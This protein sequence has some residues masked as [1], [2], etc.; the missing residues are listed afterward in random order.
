ML[1]TISWPFSSLGPSCIREAAGVHQQEAEGLA[2]F[3]VQFARDGAALGFLRIDEARGELLQLGAAVDEFGVAEAGLALEAKD[4]DC[5]DDG[6][7]EAGD[8][9]E[10]Q[11]FAEIILQAAEFEKV[12]LF[13][14]DRFLI[15]EQFDFFGDGDDALAARQ[16]FAGD[17]VLAAQAAL[18]G[19]PRDGGA[20]GAIFFDDVVLELREQCGFFVGAVGRIT[21]E[22]LA[23]CVGLARGVVVGTERW[24]AWADAEE[25]F[26]HVVAVAIRG[27]DDRGEN[28]AAIE[29]ASAG[30]FFGAVQI[31]QVY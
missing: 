16:D 5:A 29:R 17:H 8:Q 12:G 4:V 11:K 2:D 18:F 22:R 26:L 30:G 15:V 31:A 28:A 19:V 9:R 13:G 27:E 14:G 7:Q 25:K 23:C 3:V 6:E 10:H 21:L 20:E 24:V 1:R